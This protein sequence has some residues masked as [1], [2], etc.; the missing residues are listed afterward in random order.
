MQ[1]PARQWDQAQ[2]EMKSFQRCSC[3]SQDARRGA[4]PGTPGRGGEGA[5]QQVCGTLRGGGTGS[6]P[7]G[8]R[9]H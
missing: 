7:L 8:L 2:G 1:S 6:S 9:L 4:Q 3:S 5:G